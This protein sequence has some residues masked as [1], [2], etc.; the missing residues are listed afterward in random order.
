M[1]WNFITLLLLLL[2]LLCK[3]Y[4]NQK[5][6]F[7]ALMMQ[8]K[9]CGKNHHNNPLQTKPEFCRHNQVKQIFNSLFVFFGHKLVLGFRIDNLHGWNFNH[10]CKLLKKK[11]EKKKPIRVL[12]ILLNVGKFFTIFIKKSIIITFINN[13][14]SFFWMVQSFKPTIN[15]CCK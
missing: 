12:S 10:P 2:L 15:C 8:N 14:I 1:N 4:Y 5:L 7:W 6:L 3:L 9:L 11:W 13:H